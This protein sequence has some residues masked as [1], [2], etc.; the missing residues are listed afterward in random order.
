MNT[1]II[2]YTR[3]DGRTSWSTVHADTEAQA[4]E[5]FHNRGIDGWSGYNYNE[6]KITAITQR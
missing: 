4:A 1:Y 5:I 3:P 2:D 6:Y